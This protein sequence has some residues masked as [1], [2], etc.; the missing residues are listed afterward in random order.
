MVLMLFLCPL[1]NKS[2]QIRTK[3]INLDQVRTA[4]FKIYYPPKLSL[5][6]CIVASGKPQPTNAL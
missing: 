2:E 6:L 3:Q 1:E 5:Y 4:P